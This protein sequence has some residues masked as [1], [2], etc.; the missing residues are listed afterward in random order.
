[1]MPAAVRVAINQGIGHENAPRS[2]TLAS[3][4]VQKPTG[5]ES[6]QQLQE[7][8]SSTIW[9]NSPIVSGTKSAVK[10]DT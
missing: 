3:S 1:M 4:V 7:K 2:G 9:I 10:K 6:V 8:L 5:H